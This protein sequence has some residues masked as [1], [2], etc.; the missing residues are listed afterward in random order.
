MYSFTVAD[1]TEDNLCDSMQT[2]LFTLLYE[3]VLRVMK[4]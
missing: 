3:L 4:E 2:I 1:C